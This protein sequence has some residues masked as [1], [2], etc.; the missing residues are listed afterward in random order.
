MTDLDEAFK[1]A[2]NRARGAHGLF[3][4]SP[5]TISSGSTLGKNIFV[6]P[7]PSIGRLIGSDRLRSD[8]SDEHF[9]SAGSSDEMRSNASSTYFSQTSFTLMTGPR[10]ATNLRSDDTFS[11]LMTA[12]SVTQVPTSTFT[13]SSSYRLTENTSSRSGDSDVSFADS[14]SM[15]S[16][17]REGWLVLQGRIHL[18]IKRELLRAT[19]LIRRMTRALVEAVLRPGVSHIRLSVVVH[20]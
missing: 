15:L 14:P 11:P 6:T 1:S 16:K 3:G 17:A 2:V 19:I 9:F 8:I 5:V 20:R 13:P 4:G 7:P 12:V 10:T 18:A